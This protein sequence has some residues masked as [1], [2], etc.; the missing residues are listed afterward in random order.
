MQISQ[1]PNKRHLAMFKSNCCSLHFPQGSSDLS[2]AQNMQ[3]LMAYSK[4]DI[5][6]RLTADKKKKKKANGFHAQQAKGFDR[7]MYLKGAFS[8]KLLFSVSRY[9]S[10]WTEDSF[11]NLKLFVSPLA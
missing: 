5:Y 2:T 4:S 7:R 11:H 6:T 8:R 3:H 10:I 9:Q 1:S